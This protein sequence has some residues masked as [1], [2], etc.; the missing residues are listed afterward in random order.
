M[1]I[2]KRDFGNNPPKSNDT[3]HDNEEVF[4]C[5]V[6][7][8]IF[9]EYEDYFRHV[10]MINSTVWQCEATGREN[11][12]YAEALK[13][14]RKYRRKMEQF[15]DS[16]R[17][18][19]MLVI[20]EAKQSSIGSLHSILSKFL[21][22]RFFLNEEI[23]IYNKSSD[24]Y[25]VIEIIPPK[26]TPP[27]NGV[28][29]DT[30]EIQYR[31]KRIKQPHTETVV[32]FKSVRRQQFELTSE[33]LHMFIRN[34][35]S[36]IEGI[37]RPNPESYK[38]YIIDRKIIFSSIFIGKMPY[39]TPAKIKKPNEENNKKQASISNYLIKDEKNKKSILD[40]QARIERER[41]EIIEAKAKLL[42]EEKE[43]ERLEKRAKLMEKIEEECTELLVKTDDLERKDQ[44]LLPKF[45]PI[46]TIIPNKLLGDAFMLREFMH[47]FSGI[48]SGA[49]VFRG[50]LNFMEMSRAFTARE[51]A[52]PL[53]DILLVLIGTIFD[54]QKEEEEDCAVEYIIQHQKTLNNQEPLVSMSEASRTHIYSKRHFSFKI[55]ELPLDSLTVSEVLRLHILSSGAFVK[56]RAEKWRIAYRNGYSNSEDPGLI[57]RLRFPHILRALNMY[58]VYHLPFADIMRVINC[59]MSQILTYSSTINLIEERMEQMAKARSELRM[60]SIKENKRQTKV[61]LD[62]RELIV[63]HNQQ[64]LEQNDKNEN[65][66]K[67][68]EE[69]LNKKIAELLAQS[70]RE[71]RKHEQEVEE[72]NTA[73]LSLNFN[74]VMDRKIAE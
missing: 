65:Q 71:H 25:K 70:E 7:K 14:E 13:S 40:E 52:G 55:N 53:S 27:E 58:T 59:L 26:G 49:E 31:V 15:K 3:F 9:R 39:F 8:E 2:C 43:R 50:N 48:L 63:K 30:E 24:A 6:T 56:E 62:K 46:T 57:L 68:L 21:R 28:Y 69:K 61:Q 12:T 19:V 33:N 32:P 11:L 74:E 66:R 67:E 22:R 36:R 37:L 45:T 34:N 16:L 29:D 35:V 42:K 41:M 64:F 4:F 44:R 54:L 38:T 10:M 51:V 18:V 23:S 72:L 47:T 20:E 60:L 1:P 17:P 73:L 5:E